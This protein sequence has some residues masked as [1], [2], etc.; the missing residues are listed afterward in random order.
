M[1]S[2]YSDTCCSHVE[3]GRYISS[4]F[5]IDHDDDDE[6]DL[7]LINISFWVFFFFEFSLLSAI[8]LIFHN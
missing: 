7:G 3:G 1:V 8:F 5:Q 2:I 4:E 6:A